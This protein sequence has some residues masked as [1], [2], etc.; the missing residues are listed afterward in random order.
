MRFR[1]KTFNIGECC[2]HGTVKITVDNL[3]FTVKICDYKTNI[4]RESKKFHFVDKYKIK[5][6]L[7]EFTTCFWAEKMVKHFFAA[8]QS[9]NYAKAY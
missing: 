7:E 1:T 4:V 3:T 6:Y 5:I 2:I 8:G 9:N